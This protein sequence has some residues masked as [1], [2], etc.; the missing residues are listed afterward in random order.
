MILSRHRT[1]ECG[2]AGTG[3]GRGVARCGGSR[4]TVDDA[5]Y[6][7]LRKYLLHWQGLQGSATGKLNITSR[8]VHN[9]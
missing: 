2:S 8:V 7:A 5:M 3:V 1:K 9:L 4:F 6:C